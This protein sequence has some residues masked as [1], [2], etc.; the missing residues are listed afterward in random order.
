MRSLYLAEESDLCFIN[1]DERL[2]IK[3]EKQSILYD[4]SP[5]FY[6]NVNKVKAGSDVSAVL[7]QDGEFILL[8]NVNPPSFYKHPFQ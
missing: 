4:R 8:M 6:R 5:T 1:E 7:G 2:I 3:V